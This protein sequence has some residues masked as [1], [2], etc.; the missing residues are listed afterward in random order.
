MFL[1]PFAVCDFANICNVLSKAA[2][3]LSMSSSSSSSV[4]RQPIFFYLNPSPSYSFYLSALWLLASVQPPV[5]YRKTKEHRVQRK[6]LIIRL[7]LVLFFSPFHQ[8]LG[9]GIEKP[10]AATYPVRSFVDNSVLVIFFIFSK[11]MK[12]LLFVI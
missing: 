11:T 5:I 8:D 3:I 1:H 9:G 2:S 10:A 7:G 4:R 12:R 6:I